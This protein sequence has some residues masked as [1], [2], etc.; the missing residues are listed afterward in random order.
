MGRP[1]ITPGSWG[2]ITIRPTE[3]GT[4]AARA[5]YRRT[6]G[7]HF[8]TEVRGRSKSAAQ[9]LLILKLSGLVKGS[10]S[11]ELSQSMKFR[12][13]AERYL[14]DTESTSALELS[15]LH[16][17][18][19]LIS[20]YV[21][22][23]LGDL[24]LNEL[25]ASVVYDFLIDMFKKTPSQ[26]KNTRNALCKIYD[27]GFRLDV[28]PVN[29][30]AGIRLPKIKHKEIVAPDPVELD[31]IRDAIRAYMARPNRSGPALS[32]LLIDVVEVILG[33]S[34]RIGEAVGL[35][36]QD[37]D[38]VSD[39]PTVEIVGKVVEGDGQPK[40]WVA[41]LKS[42]NGHRRVPIPDHLVA[43]LLERRQHASGNPYVFHTRT[44]APNG[45]QDVH[46]ALR[47]VREW[48][49]IPSDRVPHSLRK[50]VA[51]IINNEGGLNAAAKTLGH[52]E[53]RITEDYYVKRAI[54]APDMR[55]ALDKLAPGASRRAGG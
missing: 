19:R 37:V 6:D 42:A 40:R 29:H 27:Y 12:R 4:Y 22:P 3:S 18:R 55:F 50:S 39:P 47:L 34:S 9:N 7:K 52:R 54:D 13:L 10:G 49:G 25:S 24:A 8:E 26:A 44:G 53:S 38:L 20:A 21:I 46:R 33:T 30:P 2:A 23:A 28:L 5:R 48:A 11:G 32:N 45:P 14:S 1:R 35:R 16:E 17:E 41:G 51:T 15:T 43:L 36:W 31:E